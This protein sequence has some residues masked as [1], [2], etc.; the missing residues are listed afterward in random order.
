M[1]ALFTGILETL[2]AHR[3]LTFVAMLLGTAFAAA[4]LVAS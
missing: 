1:S 4:V 3:R 2:D